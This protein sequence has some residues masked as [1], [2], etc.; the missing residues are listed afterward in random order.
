MTL[1]ITILSLLFVAAC[2]AAGAFALQ[3]ANLRINIKSINKELATATSELTAFKEKKD[4]E[5]T[6]IMET[7]EA[8]IKELVATISKLEKKL[9]DNKSSDP[10]PRIPS[11]EDTPEYKSI[12]PGFLP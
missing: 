10:M 11:F 6:D 4:K 3:N 12:K 1:A 2:S 7:N 5:I 9:A 8:R